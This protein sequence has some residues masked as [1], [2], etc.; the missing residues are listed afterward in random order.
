MLGG[1]VA[2]RNK[3]LKKFHTRG[4]VKLENDT[5]GADEFAIQPDE[6]KHTNHT[7]NKLHTKEYRLLGDDDLDIRKKTIR[8]G[9]S[10]IMWFEIITNYAKPYIRYRLCKTDNTITFEYAKIQSGEIPKILGASYVGLHEFEETQYLFYCSDKETHEVNNITTDDK[11]YYLLMDDIVNLKKYYGIHVADAVPKFFIKNDQFIF[12]V[13]EHDAIIEIPISGFRG[14]YYKKIGLLAGLGMP[15]SG[16]YASLGPYFYFGDFDRSLR[17][18]A[19]TLN[20]KSKEVMG[21]KLTIGDSP[22]FT[23]GGMVKYALFMGNSKVMLNLKHDIKD[24]SYESLILASKRKFIKD[25]LSLRDSVG[26]WSGQFDSVIQPE[27]KI[28]D[29]D[30]GIVRNLDPQFILKTFEQQ[31]PLDYAYFKTDNITKNKETGFYNAL[32]AIMI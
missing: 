17:F 9:R 14:E 18:A 23:K 28:L 16:P 8:Q 21:E 26:K 25:T 2:T 27:L 22:V 31:V 15:R 13:D 32:E 29:R 1:S 4:P 12:L 19:I 7:A 5:A 3:I 11:Y 30:L 10:V 24:D 20:G 6:M